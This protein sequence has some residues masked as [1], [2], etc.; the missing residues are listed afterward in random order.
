MTF[1]SPKLI[2]SLDFLL[3]YISY[4][5]HVFKETTRNKKKLKSKSCTVK[6]AIAKTLFI[7]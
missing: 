1:Y 7:F 5:I 6:A 2:T 3:N 4:I